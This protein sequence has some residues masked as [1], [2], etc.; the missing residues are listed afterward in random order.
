MFHLASFSSG[1]HNEVT[2]NINKATFVGNECVRYL[3]YVVLAGTKA[4][5]L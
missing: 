3:I 5:I 2:E 4:G 1:V